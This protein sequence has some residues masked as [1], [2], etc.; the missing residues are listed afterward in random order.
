MLNIKTKI[1][2]MRN[3]DVATVGKRVV[4]TIEKSVA[5]DLK[6]SL[7]F[8]QLKETTI[9]FSKFIEP[10]NREEKE[11]LDGL[12]DERKQLFNNFYYVV[13]G[14]KGSKD[15]AVKAAAT[16]VFYVLNLYGGLG[17]K[18]LTKTAHTQRYTTIVET[19]K[20]AEYTE[21]ITKLNADSFLSGLEDANTAYEA[22]YQNKG[23]KRSLRI[24]S[25]EMRSEMNNAL[26]EMT[27]EV[28]LFARKYPTEAN[29]ELIKNVEQRIQEIYV[30]TPGYTR[31]ENT[32]SDTEVQD[33]AMGGN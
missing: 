23:N 8:T 14:L 10:H 26:K 32:V 18:K 17:F 19:L 29:Q 3:E 4:E 9:R 31:K 27:D 11:A 13:S 1:N 22:M 16:S 33:S 2:L 21:A 28:R 20:Q 7:L 12:F 25:N 5:E 24:P 6:K 30:P 15:E